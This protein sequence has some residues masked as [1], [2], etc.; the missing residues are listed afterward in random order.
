MSTDDEASI[1]HES[2]PETDVSITTDTSLSSMT[3]LGEHRNQRHYEEDELFISL[4][5]AWITQLLPAPL[6]GGHANIVQ[7]IIAFAMEDE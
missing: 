7:T 6:A 2:D 4:I 3:P 1:K 5:H